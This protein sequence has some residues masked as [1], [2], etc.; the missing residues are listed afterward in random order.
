[1]TMARLAEI[2]LPDFGMP[3]VM[4]EIPEST[5]RARLDRLRDRAIRHYYDRL[6]VYADREHTCTV[7]GPSRSGVR[8]FRS[9]T[10]AKVPRTM[11][12]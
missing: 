10:L 6:V 7:H 2:E 8:R 4:P 3:E 11:T 1:M 12:S 9:R 5:Y